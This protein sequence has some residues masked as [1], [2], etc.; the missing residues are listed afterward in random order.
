MKIAALGVWTWFWL[1]P[2]GAF[3]HLVRFG[4]LGWGTLDGEGLND[5]EGGGLF[6]SWSSELLIATL[7]SWVAGIWVARAFLRYRKA[8]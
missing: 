4:V 6:F 3:H 1:L 8:A 5:A 7:A 2:V